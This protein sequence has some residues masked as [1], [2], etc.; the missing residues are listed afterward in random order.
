MRTTERLDRFAEWTYKN[1]CKGRKM[2]TPANG[3]D[4]SKIVKARS[5][6]AMFLSS[7]ESARTPC[8]G[9]SAALRAQSDAIPS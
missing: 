5:H 7:K 9:H 1:L 8:L 3:M 6:A 4:F 2:K